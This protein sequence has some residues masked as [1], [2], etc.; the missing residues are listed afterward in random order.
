MQACGKMHP[1]CP[2]QGRPLAA[3]LARGRFCW[4]HKP[5][6][7]LTSCSPFPG[8]GMALVG[9]QEGALHSPAALEIALVPRRHTALGF[10]SSSS[11][12]SVARDHSP[13]LPSAQVAANRSLWNTLPLP[14]EWVLLA[15]GCEC[16]VGTVASSMSKSHPLHY[17]WLNWNPF[18]PHT[19][20]PSSA[21]SQLLDS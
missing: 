20:R 12:S 2:E 6:P 1:G 13:S 10:P 4:L 7:S 11:H 15:C 5:T 8:W 3:L 19:P 21:P 16:R 9:P 14:A 17:P 18:S